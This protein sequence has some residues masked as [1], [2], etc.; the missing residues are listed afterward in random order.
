[1]SEKSKLGTNVFNRTYRKMISQSNN[2]QLIGLL[3][4]ALLICFLVF[5]GSL[6][7][8]FMTLSQSREESYRV[9]IIPA[10]IDDVALAALPKESFSYLAMIDAGSSGCRAHVYRYGKLGRIEGPLYVLP[11]HDSKKVKPGLSSF[12]KTPSKAGESLKDL[13]DFMKT[14]V[15][16][17]AWTDT[18]IWLKA[19]A[20]LRMVE[21]AESDAILLSVRGFLGNKANSPFL[22]RDSYAAIISGNEEGGFGW[23]AYN[24]LK[25]II[26]PKKTGVEEPYAVVEM[27]GA[28]SQVSQLAPSTDAVKQIPKENLFS[29][30]VEDTQ[31]DLY[32]HSY[33]GF[34]GE[35]ARDGLS[36]NLLSAAVDKN[37]VSDPCLYGGFTRDG[38]S[39]PAKDV[40]EGV[41][42]GMK[43]TGSASGDGSCV[44]AVKGL[45]SKS[46][47]CPHALKTVPTT[48]S[49]V[50]QPSFVTASKNFLVFENFFY[51]ASALQ[52]KSILYSSPA[53]ATFP[54]QTNPRLMAE[55]SNT[56]CGKNW[57][58][59]NAHYPLDSQPKDNLK[60]CFMSAFTSEF[61][62][63]GL[64]K[65][66]VFSSVYG[67]DGISFIGISP[68][69]TIT[70]QQ[71]VD[72]AD[73]E[74]ALGAAYKEAAQLLKMT[75]L[76]PT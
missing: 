18:P 20:G 71:S 38:A 24:Y 68:E 62:T 72:G 22:F 32:T 70:I 67:D 53:K 75:Y 21:K 47:E 56:V 1:M 12:A 14:Q 59:V 7:N 76:R 44:N 27:G 17:N 61:L 57:T 48:F 65:T 41:K 54:L 10:D 5:Y 66:S 39:T 9:K 2:G 6:S 46:G 37:A 34:G 50:N 52:T 33:L 60:W 63:S 29:F 43:V 23:V 49:C 16:E 15:P 11:K 4:C 73:I 3:M 58:Y 74:W 40:Y 51:V 35:R 8:G 64:G 55:A 36:S 19:T 69:K 45:F 26:G 13:V 31:Y 42:G 25:K 28:S 30:T